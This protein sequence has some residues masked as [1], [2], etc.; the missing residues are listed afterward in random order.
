MAYCSE[1][2]SYYEDEAICG[3][4]GV[5]LKDTSVEPETV[6]EFSKESEPQANGINTAVG[7]VAPEEEPAEAANPNFSAGFLPQNDETNHL[8]KGLVKPTG[9]EVGADGF[10]FRYEKPQSNPVKAESITKGN[11]AEL[12]VTNP[13]FDRASSNGSAEKDALPDSEMNI[14]KAETGE[15][16]SQPNPVFEPPLQPPVELESESEV[17]AEPNS[18]PGN[19]SESSGGEPVAVENTARSAGEVSPE[20]AE[21][22]AEPEPTVETVLGDDIPVLKTVRENILYQGRLTWYGV[23]LPCRFQITGSKLSLINQENQVVEV[24]L[25][26]TAKVE[27]RQN[28]LARLVGTG[29]VILWPKDQTEP[30]VLPGVFHPQKIHDLLATCL[31]REV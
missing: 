13:E 20:I 26:D 5:K 19:D 22:V 14:A 30:V 25:N 7:P 12:R 16:E 21:A 28:W 11:L 10:H 29:D 23:P 27:L 9:I 3:N 2:G 18:P 31:R 17:E 8:G 1:C 24:F 4:C 15:G 6:P